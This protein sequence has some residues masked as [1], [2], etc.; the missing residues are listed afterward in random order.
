MTLTLLNSAK[1]WFPVERNCKLALVLDYF[2][3]KKG[4]DNIN[5]FLDIKK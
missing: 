3:D 2:S 4:K 1:S 5:S